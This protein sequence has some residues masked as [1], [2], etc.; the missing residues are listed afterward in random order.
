MKPGKL[1]QHMWG[2]GTRVSHHRIT[3]HQRATGEV[4]LGRDRREAVAFDGKTEQRNAWLR[5]ITGH[6]VT[7]SSSAMRG[8][9]FRPLPVST[10]TVVCSG[11]TVPAASNLVNA[12]AAWADVGST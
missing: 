11:V 9:A 1:A 8:V 7:P 6:S 10:S 5:W 2:R 4:G 12:A 3:T